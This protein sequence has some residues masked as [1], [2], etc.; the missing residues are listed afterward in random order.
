MYI[1]NSTFVRAHQLPVRYE[2]KDPGYEYP[3]DQE[4]IFS[5]RTLLDYDDN[6]DE[7]CSDELFSIQQ[8]KSPGDD[9]FI[10]MFLFFNL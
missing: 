4:P 5:S 10:H 3:P 6:F 7:D 1:C 9:F 8:H 2:I